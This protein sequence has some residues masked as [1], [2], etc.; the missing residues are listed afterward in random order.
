MRRIR[1]SILAVEKQ[2]VL[3]ISRVSVYSLTYPG[4]NAHSSNC[5]LW[6]Y[7]SHANFSTFPHKLH[8]FRQ[9]I[10]KVKYVLSFSLQSLS[11]IIAIPR[12]VER[13]VI[14]NAHWSS[15]KVPVILVRLLWI[16]N[17]LE[18]VSK[19][20]QLL[21]FIKNRQSGNPVD[22]CIQTEIRSDRLVDRWTVMTKQKS[23]VAILQTRLKF[24]FFRNI[25]HLSEDLA[26]SHSTS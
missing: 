22:T 13:N 16:L 5:H 9:K 14:K 21:N 4:Q 17:F 11:E 19:N 6:P 26:L 8:K 7:R 20:K 1:V 12:S 2:R 24:H 25:K 3:H 23:F 15:C 18:T 10:R